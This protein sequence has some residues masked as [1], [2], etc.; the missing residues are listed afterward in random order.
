M[1]ILNKH[2]IK[3]LKFYRHEIF[4]FLKTNMRSSHTHKEKK[5]LQLFFAFSMTR[6]YKGKKCEIGMGHQNRPHM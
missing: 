4:K 1:P 5:N 6:N 3:I 2:D